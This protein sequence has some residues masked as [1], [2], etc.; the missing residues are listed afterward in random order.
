MKKTL[1]LVAYLLS[2]LQTAK[3]AVQKIAQKSHFRRP[4]EKQHEKR[5]QTLLKPEG[6]PLYYIYWSL[7]TQLSWR[8]CLLVI[9]KI[10]GLIV[11][12][13]AADDKYSLLHGKYLIQP[14]QIQLS[15]KTNIFSRFFWIF[16]IWS[17]FWTFWKKSDPHSLF[18]SEITDC[19]RGG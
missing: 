13:L 8:K 19:E 14:I 18:I 4:I 9:C 3:D 11:N 5:S 17:K 12:T 10:F 1:T 15:K 6:Q 7:W 2:K 16:E